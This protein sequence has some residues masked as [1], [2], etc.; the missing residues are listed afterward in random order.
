MR[1]QRPW[2]H[3]DRGRVRK[4]DGIA[5]PSLQRS[6]RTVAAA[7]DECRTFDSECEGGDREDSVASPSECARPD[8]AEAGEFDDGNAGVEHTKGNGRGSHRSCRHHETGAG[9]VKSGLFV[10][11]EPDWCRGSW[12]TASKVRTMPYATMIGC[13]QLVS[14]MSAI[15]MRSK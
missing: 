10:A 9:G 4:G 5:E 7:D 11:G 14:P 6:Q 1:V 8:V 15:W 12:R 2:Q 13:S 3:V